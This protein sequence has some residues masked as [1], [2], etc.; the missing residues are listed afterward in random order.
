MRISLHQRL[1]VYL[2]SATLLGWIV[3]AVISVTKTRIEIE[4]LFD[5]KLAQSSWVLWSLVSHELSEEAATGNAGYLA[6]N[7]RHMAELESHFMVHKYD[8][9]IAFQIWIR[10]GALQFNSVNA[11][12][13]AFSD[14]IN[15]FSN[16]TMDGVDWRVFSH[17]DEASG[18]VVRVAEH[19]RV[20]RDLVNQIA[21]QFILPLIGGLPLFAFI[22]WKCVDYGIHPLGVV[23]NAVT[24]RAPSHLT[25]IELEDVPDEVAPLITSLNG[26]FER[27]EEM[28]EGE[29]RFT[30][31]A[32][33]ELRSP[34]TVLMTQAQIAIRAVKVEDRQRALVQLDQGVT[35]AIH[36]IEQML[37]LARIDPEATTLEFIELMLGPLVQ[38]VT[39]EKAGDA[40][41][42]QIDISLED[43][44][45]AS[46]LGNPQTLQILTRNII[47]NAIRYTPE[48]GCVSIRTED[49]D[50]G[51]V[52][53]IVADSGPGIPE[54][55]RAAVFRRFYRRGGNRVPGSGL[56]LSIV[57]R[58]ADLHS[59][60]I[61]LESSSAGGIEITVCFHL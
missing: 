39:S 51:T 17:Y 9:P 20:R 38:E 43:S 44:E 30:N 22:I 40:L 3:V 14:Q 4:E 46:I 6:G 5:A 28:L 23:M 34:L 10:E 21:W 19:R 2:L 16:T 26:L 7:T 33:H 56:G 27:I 60:S 35:R 25:R 61:S 52:A 49:R 53:L 59:A 15:G 1:L 24:A 18:I 8:S 29:R 12:L 37:T 42:K 48:G 11:P 54:Q 31:D 58:I 55:E 41:G 47:D 57:K 45:T 13:R 32:A 36:L 50:D